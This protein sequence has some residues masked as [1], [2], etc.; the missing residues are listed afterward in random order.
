[1]GLSL[2]LDDGREKKKYEPVSVGLHVARLVSI[3]D[4]G[5]QKEEYQGESSTRHKLFITFEIP[6]E[7]LEGDSGR[8]KTVSSELTFSGHSKAKLPGYIKSLNPDIDVTEELDLR[9]LLGLSL[10]ALVGRTSGGYAKITSTLPVDPK[11]PLE[12]SETALVFYEIKQGED[13]VFNALPKFL[14]DKIRGSIGYSTKGACKK[15]AS[16]A[17]PII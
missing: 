9:S 3:I 7:K 12:K 13:E 10:R 16:A 4:L 8:S 6:G 15:A 17:R 2:K 5:L 14:Q 1:M 11:V